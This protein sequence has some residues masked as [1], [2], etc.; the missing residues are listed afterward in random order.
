MKLFPLSPPPPPSLRLSSALG[1]FVALQIV[2][3]RTL[4]TT[5]IDLTQGKLY[6][7]SAGTKATLAKIGEPI[8]LRF[9]YSK[10]LGDEIPSYG[11]YAQRVREM[12]GEYAAVANGKIQ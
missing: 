9:Y 4:G 8:V 10:K 1:L 5:R 11:V 2:A 3:N 6:T 7:L 12:L